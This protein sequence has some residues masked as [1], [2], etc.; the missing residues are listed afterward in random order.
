MT[1]FLEE[2]LNPRSIALLGA[3]NNIQTMGTGQLYVLMS[4][5]KGKIYPVHPKEEKILGLTTY[6]TLEELPE[7][8]DLLIITLPT[9]LVIPYLE[10]AGKIGIPYIIIVSAGFSEIGKPENQ[11]EISEKAKLYGMRIIGPNCIGIVNQHCKQGILNCTWFPFEISKDLEANIAIA[12]QSGSWISQILVWAE[13]RGLRI[14]KAISVG[15]E[16]DINVTDCLEFFHHDPK[17][18][19]IA[20]YIEGIKKNGRKFIEVLEKLTNIKPVIV[21]YVGGTEAG[22][23]AGLSHTASLGGRPEIYETVFKQSGAIRAQSMEEL[24]EFSHA[25][26]LAHPPKGDRVGLITN[27]GGPAVTLADSCE[28]NGLKV[29]IFSNSLQKQLN[30]IIPPVASSKNPIDL[31]FDI[32]FP[33]FYQEIPKLV[34]RSGEVD[35]L[36]FYGVFGPTSIERMMMFNNFKFREIFQIEAMEYVLTKTLKGFVKWIHEEKIPVLVSCIDTGYRAVDFLQKN[37]IAVFKFPS[38]TVVAL[39]ALISYYSKKNH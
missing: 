25:F 12:S 38:T 35:S 34:W 21:N 8:P 33:L 20:L 24:Y 10:K 19:V 36:I 6:K 32:N 13:K 17:T 28:R 27:S 18:K 37:G 16:A 11:E 14:G 23:R 30:E 29:P 22:S 26:S 3:S 7:V 31:T 39:K 2:L 5:F 15:N 4:R 1:H 9:R